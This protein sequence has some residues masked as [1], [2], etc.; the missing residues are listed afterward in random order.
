MNYIFLFHLFRPWEWTEGQ[1]SNVINFFAATGTVG[2]LVYAFILDREN[3]KKINYL[4]NI[5]SQLTES[6][7]ILREQAVLENKK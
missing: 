2:A 6:N 5:V 3:S 7:Q 4:A 1:S